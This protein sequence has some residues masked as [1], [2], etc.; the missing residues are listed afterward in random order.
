VS[1]LARFIQKRSVDPWPS[2]T[3]NDYISLLNYGGQTYAPQPQMT[4]SGQK[5][6]EIVQNFE[7]VV[8]GALKSNGIVFACLVAR[9]QLFSEAVF[10]SAECP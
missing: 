7:G 3:L 5:Q 4:L 9:A 8:Q 2:L 6:E 1:V 10:K